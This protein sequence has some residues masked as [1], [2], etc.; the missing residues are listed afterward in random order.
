MY[1]FAWSESGFAARSEFW[2]VSS[3]DRSWQM[4][5]WVGRL[6]LG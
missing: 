4:I 2:A 5:A 3:G 1:M 6:L